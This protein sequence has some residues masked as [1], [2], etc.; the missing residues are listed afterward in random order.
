MTPVSPVLADVAA[1][2]RANAAAETLDTL[3]EALDYLQDARRPLAR[4]ALT[5][6]T[7]LPEA[8]AGELLELATEADRLVSRLEQVERAL[9]ALVP[10][11][12]GQP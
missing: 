11:A 7:H 3:R 10:D 2:V 9:A 5:H 1:C 6:P 12:E 4:A 8:L